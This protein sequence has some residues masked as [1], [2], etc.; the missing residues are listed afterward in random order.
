MGIVAISTVEIKPAKGST[1]VLKA[2]LNRLLVKLNRL[3]G[4]AAYS[5]AC[6]SD[7]EGTWTIT[8]YWDSTER[9]AAHFHLPCLNELFE[10]T[11]QRLVVGLSFGTFC[12]A[13]LCEPQYHSGTQTVV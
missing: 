5:L 7:P 1:A 2:R 8:G 11:A 13:P 6:G 9:M 3:S 10:L 4:C 12:R